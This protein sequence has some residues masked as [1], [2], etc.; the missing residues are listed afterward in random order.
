MNAA[1]AH[2]AKRNKACK[3]RQGCARFGHRDHILTQ[4]GDPGFFQTTRVSTVANDHLTV[5]RDIESVEKRP[6]CEIEPVGAQAAG[7]Y[8]AA[9]FRRWDRRCAIT[10]IDV[11]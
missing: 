7:P 1:S 10:G 6:P 2:Q 4:R 3:H 11:P 5:V 9:L 8:C